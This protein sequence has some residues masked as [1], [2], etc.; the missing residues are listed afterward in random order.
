[1]LSIGTAKAR[2]RT[3]EAVRDA[4]GAVGW[5]PVG[6]L[7]LTLIAVQQQHVQA[8]ME[9]RLGDRYLPLDADWPA[10]AC[11]GIEVVTRR[12]MDTLSALACTTL[13]DVDPQRLAAFL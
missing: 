6:S 11:L 7:V 3:A 9:G 8:V 2:Y 1:M 12:A 13:C 10:D 5:L 4:F